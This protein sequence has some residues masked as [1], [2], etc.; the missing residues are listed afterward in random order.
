MDAAALH[1][2]SVVCDCHCDTLLRVLD[3][4]MHLGKRLTEGH[5]DLPRLKEGGVTSQVFAVF[6]DDRYL[7]A[8]AA[9]QTLRLIDVLYRELED[10]PETLSLALRA[11]DV[12]GAKASGKVAAILGA[13][14]AEALEGDLALLRSYYRLGLRLLTLTWSRR[15]QVGD[16]V[17]EARSLGGLT[18]FGVEVVRECNRL[19]ILLDVSHLSP[20]GVSD[21]LD[22][23][24]VPVIASH[25]NAHAVV[26]HPRNLTDK[27]LSTIAVKGGLICV[28]F[29]PQFVAESGHATLEAVLDHLDH[30]VR[31]VGVEHVGLGSDFD[32]FGP[33]STLGLEDVSCLPNVTAGLAARGYTDA[34]VRSILGTNFLRVFREAVG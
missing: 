16:G 9:K 12:E 33:A 3:G 34:A 6:I 14:G 21:V 4:G 18:T 17:F 5:V 32:G 11:A 15:N 22:T 8:G 1:D 29:V 23:S 10:N 25:S 13:E 7:P 31:V 20:A 27:Q 24:A 19:G 30:I 26:A 28:T 2:Q